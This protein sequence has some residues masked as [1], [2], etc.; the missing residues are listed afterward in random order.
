MGILQT[1]SLVAFLTV[2]MAVQLLSRAYVVVMAV[3]ILGGAAP[4]LYLVHQVM[5]G[6]KSEA[7]E[8]ARTVHAFQFIFQVCQTEGIL[9]FDDRPQHEDSYCSRSNVVSFKYF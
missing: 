6:E 5:L 3:T 1:E 9:M 4:V 8:N 2:E 7:S